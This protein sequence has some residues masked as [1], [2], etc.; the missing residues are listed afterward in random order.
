MADYKETN[1][2]GSQWNRFSRVIIENPLH[3]NQTVNCVEQQVVV[4][5]DKTIV[6]DIGNLWFNFDPDFKVPLLHPETGELLGETTGS[7]VLLHVY[8]Y[9]MAQALI[10]DEKNKVLS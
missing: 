8:S 4:L 10:R 7:A 9:V 6:Q 2:V 3:E 5:G 1:V